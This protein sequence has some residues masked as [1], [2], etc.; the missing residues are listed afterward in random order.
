MLCFYYIVFIRVNSVTCLAYYIYLIAQMPNEFSTAKI[1]Q[2]QLLNAIGTQVSTKT[3]TKWLHAVNLRSSSSKKLSIVD[4]SSQ[5]K[6]ARMDM[7]IGMLKI[8]RRRKR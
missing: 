7:Q 3:V 4:H 5:K 2:I 8:E 1:L 6:K